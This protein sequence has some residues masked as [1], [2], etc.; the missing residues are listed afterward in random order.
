MNKNRILISLGIS[1]ASIL[2][3]LGCHS[4]FRYQ[5]SV[6][7]IG[8]FIKTADGYHI[9][10]YRL[11][12]TGEENDKNSKFDDKHPVVFYVAGSSET[13]SVVKAMGNMAGFVEIEW[14]VILIDRR[15]IE[16]DNQVDTTVVY[17]F[18]DKATR[19]ADVLSAIRFYLPTIPSK[20]PIILIG[21]SE[22]GDIASAAAVQEHRITHLILIGSGGGMSQADELK[23]LITRQGLDKYAKDEA[24]LNNK[25]EEI[26]QN[27]NS[28][29]LWLGHTFWRWSSYLWS[30]PVDD[31]IK[32]RIPIFLVH[33]SADESVPVESARKVS[34]AF[35]TVGKTN[36]RYVEYQGFDHR[37]RHAESGKSGLPLMEVDIIKWLNDNGLITDSEAKP[38]IERIQRAHPECF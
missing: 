4:F 22:G 34:E 37:F 23:L 16:S 28:D 35:K 7:G 2:F 38:H 26:R 21:T 14:S 12:K 18:S 1:I 6:S 36:L 10:A 33:G 27:P 15:G 30:P 8:E 29:T 11:F 9:W 20:V 5:V 31:L 17:K 24:E 19:I 32:L 13:D 25:Y 3:I